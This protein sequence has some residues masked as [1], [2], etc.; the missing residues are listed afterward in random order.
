MAVGDGVVTGS[1]RIFG[2]PVFVFS[3]D[4]TVFGGSLAEAH[5]QKICRLMDQAVAVRTSF[6]PLSPT[7]LSI[8]LGTC[9]KLELC[10]VTSHLCQS[11]IVKEDDDV[12][13]IRRAGAPSLAK[14][15]VPYL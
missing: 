10:N 7:C 6:L 13:S 3:Q 14:K 15:L 5:A 1:G 4:F 9:G 11:S 12:K 8:L 2:R